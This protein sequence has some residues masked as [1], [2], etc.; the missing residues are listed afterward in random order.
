[1]TGWDTAK[2]PRLFAQ[3]LRLCH[4]LTPSRD[5]RAKGTLRQSG[6]RK[7]LQAAGLKESAGS[8]RSWKQPFR[9]LQKVARQ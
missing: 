1:M 2:H 8:G 6:W 7:W 3:Q 4:Q 9:R 5:P